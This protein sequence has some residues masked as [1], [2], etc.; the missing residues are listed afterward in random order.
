MSQFCKNSDS[1]KKF[2]TFEGCFSL[3]NIHNMHHYIH[4]L[5]GHSTPTGLGRFQPHPLTHTHTHIHTPWNS[6]NTD[7]NFQNYENFKKDLLQM[8]SLLQFSVLQISFKASESFKLL[9]FL[10]R[11]LFWKNFPK[12]WHK[13]LNK[14]LFVTSTRLVEKMMPL[15]SIILVYFQTI[16]TNLTKKFFW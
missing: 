3:F 1:A 4:Q 16:L 13:F 2:I 9:N 15:P 7:S 12:Y 5:Q 14:N 8:H 11:A 6:K 10:C